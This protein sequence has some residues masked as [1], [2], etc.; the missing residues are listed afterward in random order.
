[1]T[2]YYVLAVHSCSSGGFDITIGGPG[3]PIDGI[4]YWFDRKD[5]ANSFVE[6][7]NLLYADAKQ[8]A[9]WR[10]SST[11]KRMARVASNSRSCAT[12]S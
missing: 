11:R 12:A 1:M 7:L 8:L 2:L 10:E 9:K 5:E 6:N 3:I 4:D